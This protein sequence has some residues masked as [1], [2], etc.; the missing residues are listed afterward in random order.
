MAFTIKILSWRFRHL[1]IVGVCSKE[2]LSRGGGGSR[3]PQDPTSYAPV[4][5]DDV[6]GLRRHRTGEDMN[7]A[8]GRKKQNKTKRTK[9]ER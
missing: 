5:G 7:K 9:K 8:R 3:A 2:G 1:N 6:H 4:S